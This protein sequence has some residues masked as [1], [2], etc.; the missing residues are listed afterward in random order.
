MSDS[1]GSEY[2]W[3]DVDSDVTD[4]QDSDNA[5][6]KFSQFAENLA[7]NRA[8]ALPLTILFADDTET[9][10][11]HTLKRRKKR[12]LVGLD[13]SAVLDDAGTRG[14]R[15]PSRLNMEEAALQKAV[16]RA[17]Q[18]A[19]KVKR[20]RTEAQLRKHA[21]QMRSSRN[22]STRTDSR[23]EKRM[24]AAADEAEMSELLFLEFSWRQRRSIAI[25]TY[26]QA[27]MDGSEKKWAVLAA[28]YAAR[29]AAST[30]RAWIAGWK[31]NEG[32]LSPLKWG[33]G[34]KIKQCLHDARCELLGSQPPKP[35][36]NQT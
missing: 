25:S 7:L 20:P 28:S 13:S 24:A 10:A 15:Q 5:S 36:K 14:R 16:N 21:D 19:T 30:I 26:T 17:A 3:T 32:K 8:V 29:A 4:W 23:I 34:K 35:L 22:N 12:A 1:E 31:L 2:G 27:R 11:E 18:G 6:E 33:K 9:T